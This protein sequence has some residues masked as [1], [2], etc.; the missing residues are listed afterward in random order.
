MKN[1]CEQT[2]T[3]NEQSDVR[4]LLIPLITSSVRLVSSVL[5]VLKFLVVDVK[6]EIIIIPA[7][8]A[9]ICIVCFT[10]C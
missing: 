2:H 8:I 6:N 3:R 1:V 5:S 9:N 4:E 7:C 10:I